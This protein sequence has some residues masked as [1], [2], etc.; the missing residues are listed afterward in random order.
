MALLK[1]LANLG[2]G[3]RREIGVL[4]AHRRVT[5]LEGRPLNEREAVRHD[6]VRIDGEPLDPPPGCVIVLHKPLGYV[7]STTDA[8][9]PVVYD[10]LPPRF[11]RRSPIIAPVGRLDRDTSGLLLLTDN[12]GLNHRLTSPRSHL[13]KVYLATLAEPLRGDERALFASGTLRLANES[14]A[15]APADLDVIDPW[16]V[17]ITLHEGRYH[18][19]RR[20]FGAV[21]NHVAQLQRVSVGRLS[22]EAPPLDELAPRQWC[23]LPESRHYLLEPTA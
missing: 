20:M 9:N 23:L 19:V 11:R 14:D 8:T 13:A 10:L 6:A 16:H 5:D 18:Q 2:Y 15:L 22:L 21:G 17:R 12:G 3:S 1:Y 4:F 7:C